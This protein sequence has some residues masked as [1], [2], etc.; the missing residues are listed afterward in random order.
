MKN[1]FNFKSLRIYSNNE[2]KT[3]MSISPKFSFVSS[4]N[5]NNSTAKNDVETTK[6][7]LSVATDI[8][9]NDMTFTK[10][11]DEFNNDIK[12]I[13]SE[14]I[15]T[16]K[17][18]ILDTNP[19]NFDKANTTLSIYSNNLKGNTQQNFY[20]NKFS[21]SG[22]RKLK[23]QNIQ[24][25]EKDIFD[26]KQ[27]LNKKENI[28]KILEKKIKKVEN[29]STG[30]NPKDDYL[31][32][33]KNLVSDLQKY[34]NHDLNDNTNNENFFIKNNINKSLNLIFDELQII[35]KNQE[36]LYLKDKIINDQKEE[37]T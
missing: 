10:N 4:L 8:K 30:F 7:V 16:D 13:T 20:S 27:K 1:K 12:I 5:N 22:I 26:L 37:I 6:D 11:K 25:M 19:N 36:N 9:K 21:S 23:D 29:C 17:N 35:R 14:T 15:I 31:D 2:G 3:I 33:L 34:I 32:H 18:I 28:N 24:D